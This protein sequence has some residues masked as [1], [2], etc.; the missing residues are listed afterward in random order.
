MSGIFSSISDADANDFALR[1]LILRHN[2]HSSTLFEDSALAR[3]VEA[4]PRNRFHIN[5][6][7]RDVDDPRQWREGDMTGLP[8]QAV[9]DAV[10]K[11]NIWVHLQRIQEA[12]AAYG[13]L[14]NRA[15]GE[16]EQ[17]IPGFKSFKRSMS[18]LVSSPRMNVAYHADVPGQSLWQIR[19]R[20]RVWIYPARA[21]F[22]P[23]QAIENIV[24]KRS[25]DTDLTFDPRFDEDAK[26]FDLSPGD[27]ASWPQNCPHRVV[28]EDCLNVSVTMEHWNADLRATYAVN[29]ANGL[30]R[31]HFGQQ[32][33]SQ[34]TRGAAFWAKFA[35]AGAHKLLR[36]GKRRA[37]PLKIDFRV[38]PE[39]QHGFSDIEPYLVLK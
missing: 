7:H 9:L 18:V 33:L 30:L 24:L 14:L 25:G 39:S 27:M 19:G 22:L 38:D 12:D 17:K 3:L 8:G 37:L 31:Q 10:A 6:I 21:P 11:G 4:T 23:Q 26:I 34:A 5:T 2:F 20:K 13:D 28:N 36:G 15:F 32:Q 29:Y 1:P 16:L 35:L